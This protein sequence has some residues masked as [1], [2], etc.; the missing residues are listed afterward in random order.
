MSPVDVPA[1]GAGVTLRATVVKKK[2]PQPGSPPKAVQSKLPVL[3]SDP[4]APKVKPSWRS[5]WRAASL[6]AIH[7]VIAGHIAHWL[8][9]GKTVTPVEPSEA[10]AF[11]KG[12]VVNAGLIF[13]GAAILLTAI[14]GRWFCGWGCHLVALQDLS[15]WILEKM[16][17]RPQ[18]LRSRLLGWVPALAFA[19]MFLWPVAYRLWVGDSFALRGAELTTRHFWETFPGWVVGGLTF[20]VC[21]FACVYFLGAKGFCTY[22]CPYGAAFA[23]ADRIAPLRVRVTDACEGCGHCTSVC[24]SNVRVHEEVALYKMVVDPGCM[25]C[26]D[27]V[28]VCPNDALYFGFGKLPIQ[29]VGAKSRAASPPPEHRRLPWSEELTLAGAF[30]AA[31]VAFRGL[32]GQVPFLMSLGVAGVFAF[33]ALFAVRLARRRDFAWRR[34]RLRSA[35]RLTRPGWAA[36][37]VL[38]AASLFWLYGGALRLQAAIADRGYQRTADLRVRALDVTL[39]RT[40]LAG[41]EAER[42]AAPAR[43]YERLERWGLV[44]WLGTASR[45]AALAYLAGDDDGFAR[46]ARRAATQHDA[47]LELLRIESRLAAEQGN[48]AGAMAAGERAIAL[49]PGRPELYSALGVLLSQAGSADAAAGVLERGRRHFPESADLIYDSGVVAAIQGQPEPAARFFARALEL[50]PGHRKAR[51]NLAGMLA[52][53]GRYDEAIEQYRRAIDAAPAD[54]DLR[55]LLARALAEAGRVAEARAELETALARDPAHPAARSLLEALGPAG[56]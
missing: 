15:R 44:S 1:W 48:L 10:M 51:E 19:Y 56:G 16:G 30:V 26:G 43:G 53:A 13:F 34:W 35:G 39:P 12:S 37:A 17:I 4:S 6:V 41:A 29:V 18:P 8:I 2:R 45:Q 32:F 9:A 24:T 52:Q 33:G 20:V 42:I 5:K 25:K 47:P 40:P 46:A 55:V 27:C 50:E 54:L 38:A 36:I 7:L 14:F 22:A 11:A 3:P 49:A 31:F 28:S 21:G 23:A